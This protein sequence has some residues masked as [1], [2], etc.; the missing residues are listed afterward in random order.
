M[1]LYK[2]YETWSV[3]A[4]IENDKALSGLAKKSKNYGTFVSTLK[5][6]YLKGHEIGIKTPNGIMWENPNIDTNAV[7]W[8]ISNL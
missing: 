6:I 7:N 1:K 2:N 8:V 4:W 3:V 5:T